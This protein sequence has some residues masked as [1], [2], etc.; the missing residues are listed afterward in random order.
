MFDA[1]KGYHQCPLAVESQP[2]TTFITSFGGFAF[3][4]APYGMTSIAEH[5]NRRMDEAFQGMTGFR[6][7]VDDV[8]IF[9]RTREEHIKH[10]RAFLTRCREK[11]I[12]LNASK[13]Q[14]AQQD[15]G[16]DR[17]PSPPE[18][19]HE[20]WRGGPFLRKLEIRVRE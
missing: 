8:I 14:L 9:S 12:S 7:V 19:A 20:D 10:V 15:P 17:K 4:R 5:Y 11:G 3:L 2:L 16:R 13:L 1:L 18:T 6:K